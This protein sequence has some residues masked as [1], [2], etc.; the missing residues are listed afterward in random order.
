MV[1]AQFDT[2]RAS[3]S[4]KSPASEWSPEMHSLALRARIKPDAIQELIAQFTRPTA[5][6]ARTGRPPGA[7]TNWTNSSPRAI[8]MTPVSRTQTAETRMHV[9]SRRVRE[10]RAAGSGQDHQR[11][12]PR[13]EEGHREQPVRDARR[14]ARQRQVAVD[15]AA[16]QEAGEDPRQQDVGRPRRA[17]ERPD[18][19]PGQAER[20][21]GGLR[22]ES[23][24]DQAEPQQSLADE[25]DARDQAERRLGVDP[26]RRTLPAIRNPAYPAATPRNE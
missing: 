12:R 26:R 1:R 25:Q 7:W 16:G 8:E 19:G 5:R 6:R 23:P 20:P 11:R 4:P 22:P 21:A 10:Q 13:A 17:E 15:Q 9:P 3:T 2:K 14:A 24:R 18:E